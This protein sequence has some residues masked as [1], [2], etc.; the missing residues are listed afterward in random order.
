MHTPKGCALMGWVPYP[1]HMGPRFAG[2]IIG[3]HRAPLKK[4]KRNEGYPN[5]CAGNLGQKTHALGQCLRLNPGCHLLQTCF[6]ALHVGSSTTNH[7][8]LTICA[9]MCPYPSHRTKWQIQIMIVLVF[10]LSRYWFKSIIFAGCHLMKKLTFP[11]EKWVPHRGA[12][13]GTR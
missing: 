3:A 7:L 11:F 13:M 6:V 8:H 10:I 5:M 1:A 9:A 2:P 4:K 12:H